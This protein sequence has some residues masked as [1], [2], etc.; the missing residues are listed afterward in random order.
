MGQVWRKAKA[1]PVDPL[2]CTFGRPSL[3]EASKEP[4]RRYRFSLN[5]WRGLAPDPC[6]DRLAKQLPVVVLRF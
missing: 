1:G 2:H 4:S 3:F 5:Y 6:S